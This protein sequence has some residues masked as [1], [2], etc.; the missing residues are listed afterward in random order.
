MMT[1]TLHDESLTKAGMLVHVVPGGKPEWLVL[2]RT[3]WITDAALRSYQ[4]DRAVREML[5]QVESGRSFSTLNFLVFAWVLFSVFLYSFS[6][7]FIAVP[8]LLIG[9]VKLTGF[10]RDA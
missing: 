5:D 10:R 6:N 3:G 9:V 2:G 7:A 8:A 4:A 1:E